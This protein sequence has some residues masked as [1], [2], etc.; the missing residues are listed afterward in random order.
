[1]HYFVN[2]SGDVTAQDKDSGQNGEVIYE[3]VKQ[4]PASEQRMFSINPKTGHISTATTIDY[5][6][7]PS[8]L[9]VIKATGEHKFHVHM[10]EK[11]SRIIIYSS[12]T[13]HLLLLIFFLCFEY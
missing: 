3:I 10:S 4:F 1:M 11:L 5:E 13:T 9:L 12:F 8:V 2:I 7:T 6:H